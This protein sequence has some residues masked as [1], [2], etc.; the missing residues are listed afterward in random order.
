MPA[1]NKRETECLIRLCDGLLG[2][3]TLPGRAVSGL[4]RA[5]FMDMLHNS[6]GMTD[7]MMMDR[8]SVSA[9]LV[10]LKNVLL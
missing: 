4:D 3:Q 10:H 8:G 5:K 2:D 9:S 6:F 1:V 7:V